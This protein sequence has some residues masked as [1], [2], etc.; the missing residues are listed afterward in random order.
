MSETQQKG[1]TWDDVEEIRHRHEVKDESQNSISR[2]YP[3]SQGMISQIV[4]Y[5]CWTNNNE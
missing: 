1:L 4:N 5:N 2:D 3:V